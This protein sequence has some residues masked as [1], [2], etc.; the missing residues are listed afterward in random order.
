MLR[1]GIDGGINYIDTAYVYHR[2]DSETIVGKALKDGY[3]QKVKITT[4]FPSF[5]AKEKGDFDK[6]LDEQLKRLDTDHIDFYLL[7]AL[8]KG[9]WEN[10][11]LKLDCLAKAEKAKKD[12]R[13][14][15]IGFSFH[16][17]LDAFYT[18][19][20]GY[21][22]WEICLIQLN[23]L[24]ETY[25]QG[26]AGYKWL[27]EKGIPAVI[28]EPLL[29]GKLANLPDKAADIFKKANPG[30]PPV[31]W[32]FDYLWDMPGV[33]TTISG[34]SSVEQVKQNLEYAGRSSAGMLSDA[35]KAAINAVRDEMLAIKTVPC[36]K[37]NY[38]MPCPRGVDIPRNFDVYN[39]LATFENDFRSK[40]QYSL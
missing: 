1:Y 22:N 15:H 5:Y 12:G 10:V 33:A 28:M 31:E 30:K 13:I 7:H 24:N 25:Q 14:G 40:A 3:R 2:G 19:A 9:S 6:Y 18:I 4:K 32:A 17:E 37:C 38:C 8:D 26:L 23:Y 34:M 39:G 27:E 21:D 20:N 35:D 29:G 11:I 36:T 16:D